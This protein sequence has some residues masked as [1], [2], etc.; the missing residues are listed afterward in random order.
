MLSNVRKSVKKALRVYYFTIIIFILYLLKL[1]ER[2]NKVMK[3]MANISRNKI[4]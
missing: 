2:C 4:I 1:F 3:V